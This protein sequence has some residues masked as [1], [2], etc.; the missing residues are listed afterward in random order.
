M[1]IRNYI[2]NNFKNCDKNE[3]KESIEDSINSDDE[4]VL[5]GLGV[6]FSI[7]A[8]ILLLDSLAPKCY[9]V[10]TRGHF[11]LLKIFIF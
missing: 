4:V 9:I 1:S 2:I 10:L 3:I 11:V 6:L 7:S 5:P 8:I